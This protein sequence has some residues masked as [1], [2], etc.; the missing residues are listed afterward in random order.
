MPLSG[1]GS[2]DWFGG[3]KLSVVDTADGHWAP[4]SR[5][6]RFLR[7]AW[8]TANY[9]SRICLIIIAVWPLVLISTGALLPPQTALTVVPIVTIACLLLILLGPTKLALVEIGLL[10]WI[11]RVVLPYLLIGL[12]CSLVPL[13]ASKALVP[14]IAL[15]WYIVLV[16]LVGGF[17]ATWCGLAVALLLIFSAICFPGTIDNIKHLAHYDERATAN[18]D[19]ASLAA[20]ARARISSDTQTRNAKVQVTAKHGIVTLAGT[21]SSEPIRERVR[22]LA[23]QITGVS[24]V[25]DEVVVNSSAQQYSARHTG[26]R[27]ALS[28]SI[29]TMPREAQ[30][31]GAIRHFTWTYR[32]DPPGKQRRDWLQVDRNNWYEIYE[33]GRKTHFT[34][35]NA[36]A[37][38]DGVPGVTVISDVRDI[39]VF[40][41][42]QNAASFGEGRWLKFQHPGAFSSG[43]ALLA[44]ITEIPVSRTVATN[45]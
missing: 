30:M 29:S 4:E 3:S 38:V 17:S 15:M 43:W 40:V 34:V 39:V 21:V 18:L 16:L 35:L 20:E 24:Q 12:Y 10:P 31:D 37:M 19:D 27:E 8:E 22:A 44:S 25:V 23:M 33:D 6:W 41:P 14:L 11:A 5:I 28:E 2:K 1:R 36:S 45:Q 13:G 32:F 26:Q 42:N 9:I 7:R